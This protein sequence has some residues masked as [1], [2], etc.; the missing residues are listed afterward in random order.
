VLYLLPPL[1]S[2]LLDGEGTVEYFREEAKSRSE[3]SDPLDKVDPEGLCGVPGFCS[4]HDTLIGILFS[5]TLTDGSGASTWTAAYGGC[6]TS[7][8]ITAEHSTTQ[9]AMPGGLS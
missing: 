9:R 6:F 8:G 3:L 2:L 7:S 1:C 5:A 4:P